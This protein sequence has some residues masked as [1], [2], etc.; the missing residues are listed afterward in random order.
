MLRNGTDRKVTVIPRLC[1]LSAE[2]VQYLR[3]VLSQVIIVDINF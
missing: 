3:C 1:S 2:T